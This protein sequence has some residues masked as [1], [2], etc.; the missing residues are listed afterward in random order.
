MLALAFLCALPVRADH[1][2]G[3]QA[4]DAG[5][6]DEALALAGRGGPAKWSCT[7]QG[8]RPRPE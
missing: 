6:A 7:T 8:C 3:R 2:A 1:E 4:W 5:R